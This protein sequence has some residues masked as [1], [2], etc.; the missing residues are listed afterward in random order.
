MKP[1]AEEPRLKPE[2]A[3]GSG[4]GQ[5][6]S[7]LAAGGPMAPGRRICRGLAGDPMEPGRRICRGL[8]VSGVGPIRLRSTQG[9]LRAS[10][11]SSCVYHFPDQFTVAC[12]STLLPFY[13]VILIQL[14]GYTSTFSSSKDTYI[15]VQHYMQSLS[16]QDN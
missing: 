7:L 9:E 14:H 3:E 5:G 8:A 13:S 4:E 16:S 12:S 2:L 15:L 10:L 11:L 6:S 1:A